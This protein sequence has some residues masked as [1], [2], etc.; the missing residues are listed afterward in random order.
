MISR[1]ERTMEEYVKVGA[2]IRLLKE[3]YPRAVVELSKILPA[4][5]MRKFD[6]FQ[7]ALMITS[8]LAEEQLYRDYPGL[9]HEG[10][11]VFYGNLSEKERDELD[12]KVRAEVKNQLAKILKEKN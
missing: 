11:H 8:S 7:N 1:K 5:D 3:V 6:S 2:A 4:K 10:I 9:G 12:K